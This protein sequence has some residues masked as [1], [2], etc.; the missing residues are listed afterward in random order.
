MYKISGGT[1]YYIDDDKNVEGKVEASDAS[2]LPEVIY[3]KEY[4][5]KRKLIPVYLPVGGQTGEGFHEEII[6]P[7]IAL[8]HPRLVQGF[9]LAGSGIG[10]VKKKAV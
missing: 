4:V 8:I 10:S 9:P 1:I 3:D 6:S 7:G 5:F 2:T